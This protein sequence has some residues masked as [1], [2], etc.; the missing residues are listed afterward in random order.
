MTKKIVKNIFPLSIR[1]I[2]KACKDCS[3]Q[4]PSSHQAMQKN[5]WL[6]NTLDILFAV[7]FLFHL[8]KCNQN[9][10]IGCS[11]RMENNGRKPTMLIVE[12]DKYTN[13]RQR[14]IPAKRCHFEILTILQK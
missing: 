5:I 6:K 11:K 10:S 4:V 12:N 3:E 1:V 2:F 8:K 7:K 13:N 9:G 14:L